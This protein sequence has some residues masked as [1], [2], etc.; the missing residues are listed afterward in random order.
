V[1]SDGR[2]EFPPVNVS[3]ENRSKLMATVFHPP[4]FVYK[5]FMKFISLFGL[6]FM[7]SFSVFYNRIEKLNVTQA[8]KISLDP[9]FRQELQ[10]YYQQDIEKLAD[11]VD[12]DLSEWR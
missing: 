5:P 1:T 4:Q 2:K 6:D 7:K 11:I 10:D 9:E 3:F 8:K 12:R